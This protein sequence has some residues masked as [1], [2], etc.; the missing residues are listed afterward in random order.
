MAADNQIRS[1]KSIFLIIGGF[2]LLLSCLRIGWVMYFQPEEVPFAEPGV[3]DLSEW[4][5]S[6]N[7]TLILNGDW[8][9][10]PNQF[11]DTK[12]IQ[13]MEEQKETTTLPVP[14]NW[15]DEIQSED[16][17]FPYGYGTYYLHISLPEEFN[18]LLGLKFS[19]IHT[20]ASIY[21]NDE[22]Q[23]TYGT[24]GKTKET[25]H[26]S[27]SPITEIFHMEEDEMTIVV[28]LA[29]FHSAINGGLTGAVTF[30]PAS[31]IMEEGQL[32]SVL[33]LMIAIIYLLHALYGLLL[34]FIGNKKYG[35]EIFYFAIMLILH[36]ITILIDD[37]VVLQLPVDYLVYH[38]ILV[39]L[40]VGTLLGNVLFI[41]HLF[42][43]QTKGFKTVLA[44]FGL[45]I[46]LI[47]IL[48]NEW[49][50][51]GSL[52]GM[53]LYIWALSFLYYHVIKKSQTDYSDVALI[54]LFLSA[55]TSNMIWG[56]LINLNLI[57]IP[58]YPLDFLLT[59]VS[60]ATILIRR[61]VRLSEVNKQQ[62]EELK[63]MDK[64]RD[65]FLARTSH[66]LRNPLHGIINIAESML[67]ED[68]SSL[69]QKNTQ[70]LQLLT[71][72]GK[73]MGHTLNDLN[74][75]TQ[76]RED[77]INLTLAPVNLHTTVNLVIDMFEFMKEGKD[78]E[79][80]CE[81]PHD[82]PKLWADENR[83][84]QIL[85]NIVHNAIK[86]TN[87]GSIRL[88]AESQNNQAVIYVIDTG[89]GIDSSVMETVFDPYEQEEMLAAS[90]GGLGI[91]LT[92]SKQLV[93]LH[94]G[95]ITFESRKS[96]TTFIFTIPIQEK[97]EISKQ[98]TRFVDN[99]NHLK[100]PTPVQPITDYF[101]AHQD[102]D[103][104]KILIVDDEP[105]N[106]KVLEQILSSEYEVNTFLNPIDLLEYDNFHHVD[107]IISDIMMP[108]MSG[109]QLTQEIR[110]RFTLLEIPILHITARSTPEDL[111]IS[112]KSG[113]NDYLAKPIHALELRLRVRLLTNLKHYVKESQKFEAAWL[114]AQIQPH[115]LF[116]TLNTIASLAEVDPD[117]MVRT[118]D[119]FGKY[120]QESFTIMN[121]E[122]TTPIQHAI[123]LSEAYIQIEK[124]RFG[125]R[126]HVIQDID[127]DVRGKI[128][129]L[130]IQP[131]IENAINHGVLMK[132]EGGTVSWRIKKRM[133]YTEII[134]T[135]D[136][137]G[138][139]EEKIKELLNIKPTINERVGIKNTNRRLLR[140]FNQ[141][142]TIDSTP[143]EGTTVSF[144]I[145]NNEQ[146]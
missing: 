30:G 15:E 45:M 100:I 27:F 114:Q 122:P 53:I 90:H 86:Y 102:I 108:E 96:G 120:L 21:L 98:P 43:I 134:V 66:E 123:K 60:I 65:E 67:D 38:K 83:L 135:D 79:L 92:V 121:L 124:A 39:L 56:L 64:A 20:S 11:V 88:Q 61:H 94:G 54:L 69:N 34:Y 80:I 1:K 127:P 128:P 125:D 104:G 126:L 48:P 130:T 116:N 143:G 44:F 113:A 29:N 139:S 46:V 109:Y 105:V 10:I 63:R 87:K 133:N 6:T 106:L 97:D 24:V 62:N 110:K 12:T 16:T 78:I 8:G 118:L 73:R 129:P 103:K 22:L 19:G 72:I 9:F 58:F 112:F 81:I 138:M 111:R 14:H 142:L 107:L 31:T 93:E 76:L 137:V 91:G 57:R 25:S 23:G 3:L 51:L 131:L 5:F 119:A 40:F 41:K 52:F 33:Q 75:I 55:Y 115:F 84:F 145:P 42:H 35:K 144:Q 50:L 49:Y 140:Q 18:D 59:I 28:H 85:F 2:L 26:A 132:P 47:L 37:D 71:N 13:A 4:D 36:G 7:G 82:F 68:D 117:E 77:K 70:D 99:L 136:G 146:D 89:I 17:R 32:S 141:G 74:T 101:K 95:K